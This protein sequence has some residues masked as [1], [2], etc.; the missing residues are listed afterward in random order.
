MDD[1]ELK[2]EP[3]G[4]LK[5]CETEEC[6]GAG[7]A[8]MALRLALELICRKIR[9]LNDKWNR[10]FR[11]FM[12]NMA[13][14]IALLIVT[15]ALLVVAIFLPPARVIAYVVLAMAIFLMLV[16]F[17]YL[18]LMIVTSARIDKAI[19]ERDLLL[20]RFADAVAD[21]QRECPMICWRQFDTSIPG[22]C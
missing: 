4:E 13:S 9:D 6:L 11:L 12:M 15:V 5:S 10:Y 18:A 7:A 21:M 19:E 2:I 8:L 22:I 16:A 20:D 1:D 17:V 3:G 14:S